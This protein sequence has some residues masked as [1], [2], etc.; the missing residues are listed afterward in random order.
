MLRVD[1]A[2]AT[3]LKLLRKLPRVGVLLAKPMAAIHNSFAWRVIAVVP[4]TGAVLLPVELLTWSK[5]SLESSP[6]YSI[7]TAAERNKAW[8]IVRELAAADR[9]EVNQISVVVPLLLV[10]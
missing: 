6:A 5:G 1:W 9:F 10:A 7:T 4:L 2:L 3:E 8:L